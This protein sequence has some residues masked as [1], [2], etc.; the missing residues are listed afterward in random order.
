[1]NDGMRERE[2]LTAWY[3]QMNRLEALIAIGEG[4]VAIDRIREQVNAARVNPP[5]SPLALVRVL[6]LYARVLESTEAFA[7]ADFIWT[8]ALGVVESAS[9]DNRDAVEAFLRHGLLLVKMHNYDAAVAK[10]KEAVRRVEALQNIEELDRQ[11][12]LARA[13]RAQAQALEALGEFNE[14][15]STLDTLMDVKR[16]IRFIAFA[17]TRG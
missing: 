4:K 7:E 13:W 5:D 8:E 3:D 14:A 9:I 15:S 11:I 6:A 16:Q 1:M 12:I 17:P 10:I 2:D